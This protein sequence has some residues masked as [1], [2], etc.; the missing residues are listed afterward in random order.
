MEQ[1]AQAVAYACKSQRPNESHVCR[2]KSEN[3]ENKRNLKAVASGSCRSSPLVQHLRSWE[4]MPHQQREP[5]EVTVLLWLGIM[6]N[7][8][9][10]YLIGH[11]RNQRLKLAHFLSSFSHRCAECLN[12]DDSDETTVISRQAMV[13]YLIAIVIEWDIDEDWR[14]RKSVKRWLGLWTMAQWV[15]R[16]RKYIFGLMSKVMRRSNLDDWAV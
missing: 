3:A 4:Q 7:C 9:C 15:L 11:N 5:L 2:Y 16:E 12:R 8:I 13:F 1:L 6:H 14:I 10:I